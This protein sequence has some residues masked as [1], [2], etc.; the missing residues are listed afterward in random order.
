MFIVPESDAKKPENRFEFQ[1]GDK[2][3]SVPK[4][5][6]VSGEASLMFEQGREIEGSLAAFD[7]DEARTIYAGLSRDQR[8][9]FDADWIAASKV[10]PGESQGS[11]DS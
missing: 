4:L 10:S 2:T 9:A 7:D 5:G 3:Y 1:V 11:A 8:T 6:F